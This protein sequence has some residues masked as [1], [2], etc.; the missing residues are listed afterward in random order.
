MIKKLIL[1]SLMVATFLSV[2]AQQK[3]KDG[4]MPGSP[5]IPNS[6]A[7]L[8]LESNNKG[9]MLPR[10]A[11]TDTLLAAPLTA[12][13]KGMM[14]YDTAVNLVT[15]ISPGI[16]YNDGTKW[17]K[18]SPDYGWRLLGNTGT[19]PPTVVGSSVGTANFWGTT[20]SRNLAIGTRGITRMLFDTSA[21]AWGGEG[22]YM[23]H[24]TASGGN[25]RNFIWGRNDSLI[26]VGGTGNHNANAIFGSFNKVISNSATYGST[27]LI[28]G[29]FNTAATSASA[30]FGNNN[31]DSALRTVVG[32]MYNIL[33]PS[34][35]WSVVIGGGG[36]PVD[37]N[38]LSGAG[39]AVFGAT[40]E[41]SASYTLVTGYNNSVSPGSGGAVVLGE[42][43]NARGASI[44]TLMI[45]Y[46]NSGYNAA[47][48]GIFGVYN[49]DSAQFTL[50]SGESNR[51][52]PAANNTEVSGRNNIVSAP[53]SV[54][55][56]DGN[57]VTGGG[58]SAVF[59]WNNKDTASYALVAGNG[60]IL[61]ATAYSG[62][63]VGLQLSVTQTSNQIALGQYN[64]DTATAAFAIG[65][66]TGVSAR[67]N[68]ITVSNG[69]SIGANRGNVGIG[70][71]NPLNKME[72]NSGTAG[73]SG[74]RFTQINSSTSGTPSS[75]ALGVNASGDVVVAAPEYTSSN[76]AFSSYIANS[77]TPALIG[78]SSNTLS[79]VSAG[80][81][82]ITYCFGYDLVES[83]AAGS[84]GD[85]VGDYV[86]FEIYVN[87]VA[88]GIAITQQMISTL[89]GNTTVSGI[90]NLTA[91]INTIRLY[92]SRTSNIN[93]VYDHNFNFLNSSF[94]VY[95]IK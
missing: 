71:N 2:S 3:I 87:G 94:S 58:S 56:G 23:D 13:V 90:A 89:G 22:T 34:A 95:K 77:A 15:G 93:G 42:N 68:A 35:A 60:N 79:V 39:S 33:A 84:V 81:A 55:G 92:G 57:T 32:G 52:S 85:L 1:A 12:H 18:T 48:S 10:V 43:N 44:R 83:P 40:N 20:D 25:N 63:A 41:D 16:Y 9:M 91:G 45:G 30:I 47:Q 21:N 54:V 49:A 62:A 61:G 11:L 59:G 51:L 36:N 86:K 6:N 72:I 24:A 14:V 27:N 50:V 31:I 65:I 28:S 74:L 17:V 73:S 4:T 37:G 5:S 80:P 19:T 66:G 46:A 29:G 76:T 82:Q 8:E 70:T 53:F 67:Y 75:A 64:K 38:Y 26:D 7:I 78:N 88:T 69:G